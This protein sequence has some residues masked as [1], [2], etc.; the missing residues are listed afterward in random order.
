MIN[1][2]QTADGE[3]LFLIEAPDGGYQFTPHDPSFEKKMAK[4]EEIISRYRNTPR[5]MAK[6]RTPSGS[7]SATRSAFQNSS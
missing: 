3:T 4:E 1:R 7:T 5:V 6:R 2:L